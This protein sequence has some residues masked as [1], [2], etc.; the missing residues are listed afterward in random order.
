[1]TAWLKDD[2]LGISAVFSDGTSA[3]FSFGAA[4]DTALARDL[5]TGLASLV[6]PHG[7]ID[8]RNTLEVYVRAARDLA[9][10]AVGAGHGGAASGLTRARLAEFWWSTDPRTE[11]ATRRMLSALDEHA[12]EL[13]P[14][15]RDL[16]AGRKFN[17]SVTSQPLPP[18]GESEWERL[19]EACRAVV[20]DSFR[21]YRAARSAAGS[22]RDRPVP[23]WGFP[24]LCRFLSAGGPVTAGQLGR[25]LGWS[26]HTVHKRLAVRE[27]VAALF[28]DTGTALAYQ[29]LFGA[30]CGIVPDGID[31]LVTGDLDWAGD[32]AVLL[33]YV[34]G[35]TAQ[36][37]VTLNRRT[38]RLLEQWLEHS[39][40]SR[41]F[42]PAGHRTGLWI[43][44]V[45]TSNPGD[46]QHGA[47]HSGKINTPTVHGWVRRHQLLGDDG[48][49]LR[50]HR[51]RIRTTFESHRDRRSWSGSGRATV[52]PNH[53]PR[54][55]GD[56]YLSAVTP[57]QRHNAESVIEA[58]QADVLRKAHP[59]AVLPG[60]QAADLAGQFPEMVS[61]LKLDDTAIKELVAGERDVFV[62]ACAD[63]A[64][65]L[66]GP[67]GKPCPARPWVC[68]LCPLALFTPRHAGNLLRMKAF[69]GRQWLQMPA[70]HF[71][72]VF[73]PYAQRI[74]E[75]IGAFRQL[76]PAILAAA[77]AGVA[78]TD[79]E[80][81]L[82]P[83]ERTT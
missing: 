52:D 58:A 32:A 37:S 41:Q 45:P 82:L 63:P 4:A 57:A 38:V 29:L 80:L 19:Q 71:M 68:L 78:G 23:E 75:V 2:P 15:V 13:R 17:P 49:P 73:G 79:D 74:D 54:V 65:G 83:E 10:A 33:R 76:D 53:T 59:P 62:A 51:H 18:Y 34:K 81:P 40:L 44:H 11:A 50:I 77:A 12:P 21:A 48:K 20:R 6:H 35:R 14:E 26:E 22:G 61:R 8:T 31:D 30:W 39:Q 55:E 70:P 72:A 16:I 28:P 47:W 25:P 60:S 46:G 7:R 56:H 64:S 66:H 5:L 36:E 1:M 42:A 3:A 27:A 43:R 9:A 69:F 67:K 24:D